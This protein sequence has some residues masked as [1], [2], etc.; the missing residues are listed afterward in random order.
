MKDLLALP[1]LMATL[2]SSAA[3]KPNI[4]YILADNP[5]TN[6]LGRYCQKIIKTPR[7]DQMAKEEMQ[8]YRHYSGCTLCAPA[9]A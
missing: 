3:N 9:P 2:T 8:F 5:G 6:D 7:I 1:L 4:I